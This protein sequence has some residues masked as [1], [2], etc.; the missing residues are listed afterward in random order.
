M[1]DLKQIKI[2]HELIQILGLPSEASE[3]LEFSLWLFG[4]NVD[5]TLRWLQE[6]ARG[7]GHKKP[8]DLLMTEEGRKQV[9]LLIN[10]I[11]YGV[12]L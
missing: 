12:G 1:S 10:R 11:E 7:L 5:A 8:V 2:I 3:A 9:I 4:N 6:P